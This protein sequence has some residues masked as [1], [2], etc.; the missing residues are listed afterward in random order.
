MEEFAEDVAGNIER[1]D[2]VWGGWS[3]DRVVVN[4]ACFCADNM[5]NDQ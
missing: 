2:A 3:G 5:C 1:G 4:T